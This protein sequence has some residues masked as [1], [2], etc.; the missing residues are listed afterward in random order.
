MLL[1]C[2]STSGRPQLQLRAHMAF[3]A[4]HSKLP[5]SEAW[6][7]EG[8]STEAYIRLRQAG[9]ERYNAQSDSSSE[10]FPHFVYNSTACKAL[11]IRFCRRMNV[12][13]ITL[14]QKG[15]GLLKSQRLL[16]CG[17]KHTGLH[18]SLTSGTLSIPNLS[19]RIPHR[20]FDDSLKLQRGA[21]YPCS[22]LVSGKD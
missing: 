18:A 1:L 17:P 11:E 22:N 8:G 15:Q 4:E 2:W 14:L 9:D 21:T 19:G 12:Q 16:S 7:R 3:N 5:L 20:L 10:C 6:R 13:K